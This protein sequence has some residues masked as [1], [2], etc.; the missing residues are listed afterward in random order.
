ML[1]IHVLEPLGGTVREITNALICERFRHLVYCVFY[2]LVWLC[3]CLHRTNQWDNHWAWYRF[4]ISWLIWCVIFE[5]VI[6]IHLYYIF[7]RNELIV[8]LIDLYFYRFFRFV[9]VGSKFS[10]YSKWHNFF[11]ECVQIPKIV[12][13][14]NK[15]P[16]ICKKV[17]ID[18]FWT[19]SIFGYFFTSKTC[20]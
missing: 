12:L 7:F 3:C 6:F 10:L 9:Q 20:Q 17:I 14:K 16:K 15:I 8:V 18:L 11:C 2:M 1:D 13:C 5:N 4:R 19:L